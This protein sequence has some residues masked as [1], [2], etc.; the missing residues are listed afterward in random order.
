MFQSHNCFSFCSSLCLSSS[1]SASWMKPCRKPARATW[2]S[3][4]TS[5]I[6]RT[7]SQ[8]R[9]TH[10]VALSL[11]QSEHNIWFYCVQE[12]EIVRLQSDVT[13][14]E[15]ESSSLRE[16]LSKLN[17]SAG[18]SRTR[19]G[20]LVNIKESMTPQSTGSLCRTIKKS[21]RATTS[22]RK[23]PSWPH[24]W[25][26]WCLFLISLRYFT[27]MCNKTILNSIWWSNVL[28]VCFYS[29]LR[30]RVDGYCCWYWPSVAVLKSSRTLCMYSK[31]GRSSGLAFQHDSI[32]S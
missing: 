19:R 8:T 22:L 3:L 15:A 29:G 31:V 11:C 13:N 1:E 6:Y 25:K 5:K 14:K 16:E 4:Q 10:T 7:S 27:F 32:T 17:D 28:G 30:R 23:K 18:Q 20:L 24:A 9:Y 26:H 2:R 12:R 21:V